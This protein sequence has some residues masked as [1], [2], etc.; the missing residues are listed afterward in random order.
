MNSGN[1]HWRSLKIVAIMAIAAVNSPNISSQITTEI[2]AEGFSS[3]VSLTHAG[4]ERLFVV[5]RGGKIRIISSPGTIETNPFLDLSGMITAGGERG[6]LGLAFHPGYAENGY[7]FVNYTD[8]DGNT[9]IARYSISAEDPD[10]A[11]PE[12][13][14]VMLT[15]DQPYQNHNGGDLSFGPDGYLYIGTGDGGSGGDGETGRSRCP[16]ADNRSRWW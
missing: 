10:L 16:D 6:L 7:F 5:E 12:S 2:Y 14:M 15:I 1:Q 9:V 4:D 11:D 3:P 13:E 8:L